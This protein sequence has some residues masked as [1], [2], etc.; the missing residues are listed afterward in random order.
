MSK[1]TLKIYEVSGYKPLKGQVKEYYRSE[2]ELQVQKALK[3][4]T[5]E[6]GGFVTYS[7]REVEVLP[8]GMFISCPS[9]ESRF[10][11]PDR[12]KTIH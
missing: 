7:I 1:D 6:Q 4:E 11:S 3:L 10:E 8:E 2:T 12:V 5:V 9:C